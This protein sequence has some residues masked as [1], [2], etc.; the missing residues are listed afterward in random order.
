MKSVVEI[1]EVVQS[2]FKGVF[3]F[4]DR[5]RTDTSFP[6]SHFVTTNRENVTYIFKSFYGFKDNELNVQ[7]YK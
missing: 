7:L 4:A 2:T 6:N 5:N 3:P 1:T